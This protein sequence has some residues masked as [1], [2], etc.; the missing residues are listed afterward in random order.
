[1]D[2]DKRLEQAIERGERT[3]D[4][5]DREQQDKTWSEEQL[6]NMH[7]SARLNLSE[8]IEAGLRHLSEHFPG[9]RFETVVDDAGWGARISR[10]DLSLSGSRSVMDSIFQGKKPARSKRENQYSRMQILVKPYSKSTKIIELHGKGTIRNKEVLNR[11]HYQFL[12]E[13]EE[14]RTIEVIDLWIL[15]FAE[16]FAADN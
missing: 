13:F 7:S 11:N 15:E 14:A 1:M 16:K 4:A 3:R 8:H 12:A 5:K 10:D 6:R 9:F 2:F